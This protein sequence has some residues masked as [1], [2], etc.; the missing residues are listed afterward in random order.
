MADVAT[1]ASGGGGFLRKVLLWL[2]LI[3]ALG[4]DLRELLE[5]PFRV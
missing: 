2:R 5:I 3:I 4:K 1:N